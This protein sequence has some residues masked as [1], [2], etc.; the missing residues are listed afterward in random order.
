MHVATFTLGCSPLRTGSGY[1]TKVMSSVVSLGCSNGHGAFVFL[2]CSGT[3]QGLGVTGTVRLALSSSCDVKDALGGD[4][5]P[6]MDLAPGM[7][8]M[9]TFQNCATFQNF[10]SPP[11][12]CA[13]NSVYAEIM[14]TNNSMN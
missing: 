4:V 10:C 13:F 14:V 2:E 8:S 7:S 11:D 9:R 3:G 6:Y 5:L 1:S 12:A